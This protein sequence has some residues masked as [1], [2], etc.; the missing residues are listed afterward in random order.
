[1]RTLLVELL[2]G[3]VLDPSVEPGGG[4]GVCARAGPTSSHGRCSEDAADVL[5]GEELDR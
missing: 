1:M 2:A 3:G 4:R 5:R